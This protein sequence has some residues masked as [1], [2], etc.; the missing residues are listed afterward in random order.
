MTIDIK[1]KAYE[2]GNI[3]I[4]VDLV[5]DINPKIRENISREII[6]TKDD[7]IRNSLVQLGWTPPQGDAP[8]VADNK[9]IVDAII[10]KGFSSDKHHGNMIVF[11]WASKAGWNREALESMHIRKLLG[12]YTEGS[13]IG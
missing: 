9:M 3:E 6:K 4:D 13:L 10:G 5:D 2:N 8:V 1:A 12:I 7:A 11:G